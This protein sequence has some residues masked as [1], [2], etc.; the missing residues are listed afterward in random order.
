[1]TYLINITLTRTQKNIS[2][3]SITSAKIP[4]AKNIKLSLLPPFLSITRAKKS[5]L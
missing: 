5:I 2:I 1:M 3:I 4:Y